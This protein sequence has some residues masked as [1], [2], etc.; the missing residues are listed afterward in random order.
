M[1]RESQAAQA[2]SETLMATCIALG[3]W[4]QQHEEMWWGGTGW[5]RVVWGGM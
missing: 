5:D 3:W 1:S 2:A 4:A